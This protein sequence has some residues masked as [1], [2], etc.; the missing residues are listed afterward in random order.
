VRWNNNNSIAGYISNNPTGGSF[1]LNDVSCHGE[2]D[3]YVEFFE[4][5]LMVMNAEFPPPYFV[6]GGDESSAVHDCS[7]KIRF[8]TVELGP[9]SAVWTLN[10]MTGELTATLINQRGSQDKPSLVYD[11]ARNVLSFTHDRHTMREHAVSIY[12]SD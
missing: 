11:S 4:S 6:G 1:G 8:G 10:P 12:L 5:N 9:S 7:E 2:D 3:L